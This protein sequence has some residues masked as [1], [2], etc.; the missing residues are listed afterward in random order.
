MPLTWCFYWARLSQV[1]HLAAWLPRSPAL[2]V[3]V[4]RLAYLVVLRVFGRLALLA[5]SDRAK[6][7]EIL[8]QRQQVIV[9]QR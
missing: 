2:S 3:L 9:L 4:S 7:A 6:D 1:W 8:I 5:R